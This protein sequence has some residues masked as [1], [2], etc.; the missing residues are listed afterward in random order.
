MAMARRSL[1]AAELVEGRAGL[2]RPAAAILRAQ[3]PTVPGLDPMT[4]AGG[5]V[6]PAGGAR[7]GDGVDV[8]VPV[9]V[10]L[11]SALDVPTLGAVALSATGAP[12]RTASHSRVAL[13]VFELGSKQSRRRCVL[14]G[15]RRF[16]LAAPV[17]VGAVEAALPA[18]DGVV[19]P[20]C[21]NAAADTT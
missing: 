13:N 5:G 19:V 2:R 16:G 7:P 9:V 6:D 1:M 18:C 15:S 11:E 4:G 20:V 21:A 10:L 14:A 8:L 17:V 3:R 12:R